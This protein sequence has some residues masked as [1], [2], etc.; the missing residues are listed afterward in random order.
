MYPHF[1][2]SHDICKYLSSLFF[3]Y[4]SCRFVNVFCNVP[5]W[6]DCYSSFFNIKKC[7]L[8][9]WLLEMNPFKKQSV[10]MLGKC[11]YH[12]CLIHTINFLMILISEK[13]NDIFHSKLHI[14]SIPMGFLR[15]SSKSINIL[16]I[17]DKCSK[18]L[19][20]LN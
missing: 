16:K 1:L 12:G 15:S 17:V 3:V 4:K 5:I 10:G 20:Y 9:I 19:E 14:V 13:E 8:L 2:V 11:R 7:L 18:I 6:N